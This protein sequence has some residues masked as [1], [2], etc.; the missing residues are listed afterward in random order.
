VRGFGRGLRRAGLILI[1]WL[2]VFTLPVVLTG[3]APLSRR[4]T[5]ALPA[6]AMLVAIGAAAVAQMWQA[7]LEASPIRP[8]G[9]L[10]IA[11]L[12]AASAVLGMA[13]YFGPYAARPEIFWGYDAGLARIANHIRA[14][15]DAKVFLT[16][17]DRFY[18]VVAITLAEGRRAPI[19]SYNGQACAVFPET[20]SRETE[21]VVG[22][23]QDNRTLPLMQ[24]LFPAGEIVW[25]IDSPAGLYARA[26]RVPAGQTARLELARRQ[27]AD[28]GGKVRLVGYDVPQSVA[29]GDTLRVTVALEGVSTL[30][31]PYK[32]FVHV[33]DGDDAVMA[34]A[35][36]LP[37]N[38]SL[39]E[40][41][42]RPGDI[43]LEEYALPI[44]PETGPGIY[45]VI[46]GVYRPDTNARLPVLSSDLPHT[47]DGVV[48]GEINVK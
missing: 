11:V 16:P 32:V 43:V 38:F 39:N 37:C 1:A 8:L 27:R 41:D 33:R 25:Q 12:L 24:K 48:L 5:G 45:R 44:S 4:W 34:Q 3:Q 42:W 20:T 10:V 6:E 14:K 15:P 7:R 40:A 17:F 35:D 22:T 46:L 36:R 26:L 2:I 31:R 9:M 18:E 29:A 30:E 19:Q 13:D 28:L 23:E 21:W 47:G